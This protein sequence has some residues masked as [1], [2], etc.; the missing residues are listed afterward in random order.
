MTESLVRDLESLAEGV[1]THHS[2]R[3]SGSDM[4]AFAALSGDRNPLHI[5]DDFARSRGMAGR[6]VYGGLL[7]AQVSRLLGM[8][9]PGRDGVWVGLKMDFRAPLYV[10]EDATLEGTVDRVS[11]AAALVRLKLSIRAGDRLIATGVAESVV[12]PHG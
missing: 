10:D 7:V 2:F 3:V 12:K 8:E 9:L 4:A 5:D 1:A 11:E 6:V